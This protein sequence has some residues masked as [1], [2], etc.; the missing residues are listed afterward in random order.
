MSGDGEQIWV[1][2]GHGYALRANPCSG[3]VAGEIVRFDRTDA[4]RGVRLFETPVQSTVDSLV[5]WSHRAL[6]AYWEG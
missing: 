5:D 2:L 3:G 1:E 4:E 6:A